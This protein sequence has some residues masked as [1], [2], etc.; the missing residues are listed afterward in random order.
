MRSLVLLLLL[1]AGTAAAAE[2][3]AAPGQNAPVVSIASPEIGSGSSSAPA[4]VGATP[5]PVRAG[6][7]STGASRDDTRRRLMVLLMMRNAAATFSE[8]LLRSSE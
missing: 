1:V 6:A 8:A 3:K 5:V 2:E 4:T 7:S